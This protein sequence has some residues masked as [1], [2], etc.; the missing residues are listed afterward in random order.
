MSAAPKRRI[1][2]QDYFAIERDATFKSEYC[3]G[4]MFAMAGASSSH[5]FIKGNLEGELYRQLKGGPCR[6]ASSD[7]RVKVEKTGLVTY[8]DIVILCGKQEIV[9]EDDNTIKNPVCLIEVFSPSTESYDRGT[10]FRHYQQI[11]SL[12]EYILVAQDEPLCQRFVR[13]PDQSWQLVTFEGMEATLAF[14]SVQA[15]ITLVDVY[16]GVS[17]PEKKLRQIVDLPM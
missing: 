16:N 9:S 5:T 14:T 3:D 2:I 4:E 7:L 15:S 11:D 17:F 8:P 12:K 13:Q 10:K 1:S 6:A